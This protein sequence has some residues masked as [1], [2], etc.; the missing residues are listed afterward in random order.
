MLD[1]VTPPEKSLSAFLPRMKAKILTLYF[2]TWQQL[3]TV[4]PLNLS[5]TNFSRLLSLSHTVL[6]VVL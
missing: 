2:N 4:I 3:A 5:L 1:R 6:V